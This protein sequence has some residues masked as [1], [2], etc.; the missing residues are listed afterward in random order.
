MD[1]HKNNR[2]KIIL[3]ASFFNLS[4]EYAFRGYSEFIS[5][6]LLVLFLLGTY[7]AFYTI[8]E[9]LILR[10]KL[11]NFQLI[12]AMWPLGLIPMGLGTGVI[13]YQPQF[14]GINWINLLFIEIFSKRFALPIFFM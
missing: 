11:N 8:L 7:F 1:I 6:P 4:F 5:K 13:F 2:W 9:D 14:L 12:V 10:Y 3:I